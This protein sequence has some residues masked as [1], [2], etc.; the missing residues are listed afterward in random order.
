VKL[1]WLTLIREHYE[2]LDPTLTHVK[3][4]ERHDIHVSVES[5][6]QWMIADS[7]WV[8]HTQRLPTLLPTDAIV[9]AIY[10]NWW[11]SQRHMITSRD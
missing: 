3:F 1:R 4:T 2:D 9:L 8:P 7:L 10:S 11:L 5:I 6:H